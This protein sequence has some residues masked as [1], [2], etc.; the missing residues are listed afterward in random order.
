MSFTRQFLALLA[1]SLAGIPRR[2][3]SV[4]TILIGVSC[5]VGV[6]VSMLSMASGAHSQAL[7]NVSDDRVVITSL[8]AR[9]IESRIPRDEADT[10]RNLPGLR[11]G[12]DGKPMVVLQSIVPIEG[13]R[14]PAGTR[15]FFLLFG[16][17]DSPVRDSQPEVRFTEGRMF[18]PGLHELTVNNPCVRQFM[19][20]TIGDKR[21]IGGADWTVVGHFD[22]GDAQQCEALTDAETLMAAFKNNTYTQAVA[23]LQSPAAYASVRQALEADPSLH[24]EVLHEREAVEEGI[25]GLNALLNFA[26]YFIGSIMAAGATLGAVNSLYSIVDSRR[27]EIA[28]LRAIGFGSAPVGAAVLSESVVLAL[29]GA[30]L[31][32]FLA[33][34]LFNRMA[35]SPFGF[36]FHL[37]VTPRLAVI[38]VAWALTMGL[39]GGLLPALRAARLPVTAALRAT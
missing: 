30:A 38:G 33:W 28:T 27:R 1:M 5:A 11:I 14:R 17:T 10:I 21:A 23:T 2:V 20:F 15:G 19:G 31:G 7:G 18:R 32:A 22:Q 13:R 9:G 29:P 12:S 3:G 39:I 25:K 8:G 37:A 34:A 16:V 24:L 35:V 4:L 26:A 6:L 36:S